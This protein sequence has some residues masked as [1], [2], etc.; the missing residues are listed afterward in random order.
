MAEFHNLYQRAV[1]YDIVFRRDVKPEVDF[2]I[3]AYQKFNNARPQAILDLA[4]GPGYHAREAARY[5]LRALG[6]DLREEMLAFAAD[7]AAAENVHV[8]WIAADMRSLKLNSPVDIA[9]NVFDGL[10]CLHSNEDLIDHFCAIG[11]N[12]T[13]GGLYLIDVTHPDQVSIANYHS[14]SYSGERDGVRVNIEWAI[15]SPQID[16]ISNVYHTKL[17]MCINDRGESI[18][19]EDYADERIFTC[20]EIELLARISGILEPVAWYG[21]YDLNQPLDHSDGATRMIAILQRKQR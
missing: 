14:F 10:D 11:Q 4:C 17:R 3:D 7:Q 18:E 5:G 9:I 16:I 15:N 1:Y 19:I 12:L 2:I 13:P 20:P 6:L 8:E 21:A